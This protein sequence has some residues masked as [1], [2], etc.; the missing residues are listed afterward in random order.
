MPMRVGGNCCR[1]SSRPGSYAR[2]NGGV[3]AA[4]AD[5]FCAHTKVLFV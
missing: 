5:L 4:S 3:G 1:A 2:L